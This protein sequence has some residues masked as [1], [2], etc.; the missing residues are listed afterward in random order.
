MSFINSKCQ[1]L[2]KENEKQKNLFNGVKFE[3]IPRIGNV[4]VDYA[5]DIFENLAIFACRR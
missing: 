1:V 2:K 3:Q 5:F 4:E